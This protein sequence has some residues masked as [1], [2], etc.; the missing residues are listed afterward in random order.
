MPLSYLLALAIALPPGEVQLGVGW[1]LEQ[2]LRGS[3]T[4]RSLGPAAEAAE[5]MRVAANEP[6][7]APEPAAT[8]SGNKPQVLR[9]TVRPQARASDMAD[10]MREARRARMIYTGAAL[11]IMGGMAAYGL[12][13]MA[14]HRREV[15][16]IRNDP[17]PSQFKAMTPR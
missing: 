16:A 17:P 12:S 10:R 7:A 6:P 3:P 1:S 2:A 11:A 5:H 8:E 15:A 14:A 4:S 13:G 9:P